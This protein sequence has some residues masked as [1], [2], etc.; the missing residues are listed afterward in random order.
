MVRGQVTSHLGFRNRPRHRRLFP[1]IC[2]GPA[3]LF[4]NPETRFDDKVGHK[5]EY[6]DHR[7]AGGPQ[8]QGALAGKAAISELVVPPEDETDRPSEA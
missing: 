5:D 3:E 6:L 1:G 7:G 8:V 4:T 2:I